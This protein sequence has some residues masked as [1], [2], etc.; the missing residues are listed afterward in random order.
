MKKQKLLKQVALIGS[1]LQC[2]S[3]QTVM[4]AMLSE[5]HKEILLKTRGSGFSSNLARLKSPRTE[6]TS[7]E[8]AG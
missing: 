3:S 1:Q 2:V 4:S 6:Q 7:K 5:S 8:Y